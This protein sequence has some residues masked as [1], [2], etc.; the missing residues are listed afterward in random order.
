[1]NKVNLME[2]YMR[3]GQ[4]WEAMNKNLRLQLGNIRVSF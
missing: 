3:Y 2:Q 4:M 1:M